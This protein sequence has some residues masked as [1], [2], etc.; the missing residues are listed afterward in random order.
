MEYELIGEE[1]SAEAAVIQAAQAI[2]L[3][4][5][6]AFT[7]RDAGTMLQSAEHWTKLADFIIAMGE[8]QDKKDLDK[9]SDFP[10]GFQLAS[11]LE[12]YE[13]EE[14]DEDARDDCDD[15]E[16]GSDPDEGGD[17]VHE[18]HG[19]LRIHANRRGRRGLRTLR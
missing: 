10:T 9:K 18:E 3:A 13:I 15:D 7:A 16:D 4:G 14:E 1:V 17:G 12:E 19:E 8:H 6:I 2:D 5:A 11:V